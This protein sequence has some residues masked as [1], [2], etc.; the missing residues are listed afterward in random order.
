MKPAL[1]A[2]FAMPLMIGAFALVLTGC[3]EDDGV[4][5][6]GADNDRQI[7]VTQFDSSYDAQ[8]NGLAIARINDTYRTGERKITIQ[9]IVK[10]YTNYNNNGLDRIVLANNFEGTLSNDD[11]NVDGRTV[12]SPIEDNNSG[13]ALDYKVTYR[14]LNLSGVDA[15]SYRPATQSNRSA[16]IRTALN[17]Y[18][19]I[20]SNVSFPAGSVCYIPVTS[21]ER[22][23]LA[24]NNKDESISQTL[25]AW[26]NDYE[27]RFTDNRP[28]TTTEYGVGV[29][30]QYDAAT[31]T[32]FAT[33]SD[34]LYRY[35]G[36]DYKDRIYNAQRVAS[37]TTTPNMNST[38]GVV[39]CT[40]VNDEAAD[41]LEAQIK[42]YY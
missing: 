19:N 35:S 11:I 32:F 9:N 6:Y 36:V 8:A 30:N 29:N 10:N 24:F 7:T 21:S 37:G 23:F 42:R 3:E 1:I 38:N 39:D 17:Q 26:I 15:S 14:T 16:G 33:S 40:L 12:T 5:G 34:P 20:P 18:T 28:S 25:E 2:P 31:V 27:R 13:D 41:F 22:E 4:Y